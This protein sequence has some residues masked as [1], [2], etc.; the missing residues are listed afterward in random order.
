M[1][2]RERPT[3]Y[4]ELASDDPHG[5]RA[6]AMALPQKVREQ[7]ALASDRPRAS[8]TLA[9]ITAV[10]L[11]IPL[12]VAQQSWLLGCT[13]WG[14]ALLL[15]GH[16]LLTYATRLHVTESH[17][18]ITRGKEREAFEWAQ[19]ESIER[20][21]LGVRARVRRGDAVMTRYV[22]RNLSD[23]ALDGDTILVPSEVRELAGRAQ[24]S[25]ATLFGSVGVVVGTVTLGSAIAMHASTIAW[26]AI[27]AGAG[28][29]L[30][31]A[32]T[33]TFRNQLTARPD[34]LHLPRRRIPW[35]EIEEVSAS[36]SGRKSE[37]RIRVAG[38]DPFTVFCGDAD[39]AV[40]EITERRN[41]ARRM[42]AEQK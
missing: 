41:I 4:R 33:A 27:A 30:L 15:V 24:R 23:E 42:R 16:R 8:F 34:G 26:L 9:A 40:A 25:V 10:V 13:G 5:T 22:L 28:L 18:V 1:S 36:G 21:L 11:A 38:E 6:I 31:L 14:T 37:V 2:E 17:L 29:Y 19:V 3:S 12:A 39:R 20:T 35:D 7:L 32:A